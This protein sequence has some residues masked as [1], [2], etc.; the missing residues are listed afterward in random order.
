MLCDAEPPHDWP[1]ALW[2]YTIEDDSGLGLLRSE[3]VFLFDFAARD[4]A[5]Y[6]IGNQASRNSR[7]PD[8]RLSSQYFAS[9][10]DVL[11]LHPLQ[12]REVSE[13]FLLDS[14]D[15]HFESSHLGDSSRFHDR[16]TYRVAELLAQLRSH[17]FSQAPNG[18]QI[19]NIN[20]AE[21][22]AFS[23]ALGGNDLRVDFVIY[24]SLGHIGNVGCF[25]NRQGA[26][27]E[28]GHQNSSAGAD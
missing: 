21:R 11:A 19:Q 23:P 15:F 20:S 14:G 18:S 13:D 24:N 9:T 4:S 28:S 17:V 26:F 5:F 8:Y 10:L 1:A 12:G 22:A 16:R 2:R 6:E 27:T 3:I 25:R 7:A